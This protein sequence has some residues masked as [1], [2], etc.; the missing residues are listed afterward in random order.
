MFK[1][2]FKA[3]LATLHKLTESH[4]TNMGC[5]HPSNGSYAYSKYHSNEINTDRKEKY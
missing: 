3:S 1:F 5:Y 2:I 4:E